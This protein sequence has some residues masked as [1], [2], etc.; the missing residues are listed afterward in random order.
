MPMFEY[1]DFRVVDLAKDP[2]CHRIFS[3]IHYDLQLTRYFPEFRNEAST[4]HSKL[5]TLRRSFK[6]LNHETS[7]VF[8]LKHCIFYGNTMRSSNLGSLLLIA[9]LFINGHAEAVE[10]KRPNILFF[11]ADDW[12]RYASIYSEVNGKGGI[13]DVVRTPNF[14]RVA[15]QGVLFRHAHV[16]APSC[17]PCRSSLL[18]GQ[19]FWRT[20]QGAILQGAVWDKSIP[21]YPL[22][23]RDAGYHIG[24]SYKVWSPGTPPDA[25]Y[26][27][28]EHSYQKR[29]GR[30]NQF[31]E[32]VT[33]LIESGKP[34]DDSKEELYSEIRDNFKD[35]LAARD[36]DKPFCYWFGP[37]NVHRSWIKGSGKKLWQID[38]D[39]LQGKM[40]PFLPD[41]PEVREDLADY[42]GEIAAWDAG[43]GVLLAELD[44]S[45]QRENTLIVISG[46]H[47]APGFPHGKCNLYGFGTGVS[48]GISGPGV[49]G[50]RVV[51]DF[52]NL[53]DLAPTFLEAAGVNT[54]QVMTGRS[55]WPILKSEKSGLVDETRTWVVTG[56]E[57]HVEDARSDYSPY[58]QR[59]IH[60]AENLLIINFR[61]DRWPLGDPYR[62]VGD[63]IATVD[64]I[65]KTTRTTIAD[66]DASPTK[67]WLVGKRNSPMWKPHF[68]W[69]FGK[70]PKYELYDLKKDPHETKNV[71]D[72][73]AYATI[74][75]DLEKRLMSEL[76]R[77]GDPRLVD[78]GK[79][80][81]TPPMSGPLVD[82]AKKK[83]QNK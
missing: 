46:D 65:T 80:F 67:G 15:K 10:A 26:G 54:P 57:R 32:N 37:T 58:P 6:V 33:K 3:K 44:K 23:L 55:L 38:P 17:T 48:L 78:D 72:D 36:S 20:G 52:V 62:L 18:S 77:T 79:F 2:P 74:K 1:L 63:N 68:E 56:R 82:N 50:G 13:N 73:P 51:D 76:S 39:S 31:S 47:G 43:I 66:V 41:V 16:N 64:E 8:G 30:F 61:P 40:P 29:G 27:G 19:Y 34:L 21:S 49:V 60:T 69:A 70:R 7:H 12:G 81:E 9:I 24:K 53:P 42:F 25:P 4:E 5:V 45:G 71:A 22:L 11:F 75:A 59:A 35:F 83:A 28:Q 14:D